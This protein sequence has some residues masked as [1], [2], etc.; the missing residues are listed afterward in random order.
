[1]ASDSTK[2]SAI[3]KGR[4]R[5]TNSANPSYAVRRNDS[6]KVRRSSAMV[7]EVRASTTSLS[8]TFG[9]SRWAFGTFELDFRT[10]A[11]RSVGPHALTRARRTAHL[12]SHS[13]GVGFLDCL[14][15]DAVR[16]FQLRKDGGGSHRHESDADEAPSESC[17][18]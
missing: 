1:M 4:A 7:R 3:R 18:R 5:R 6:A 12:T 13:G 14:R 15:R 9:P 11:H 10:P 17:Q 8:L 16:G 2:G